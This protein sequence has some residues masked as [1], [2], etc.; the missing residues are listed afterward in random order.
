MTRLTR[1]LLPLVLGLLVASMAT[2]A[3]AQDRRTGQTMSKPVAKKLIAAQEMLQSGKVA[4]A[5]KEL[6]EVIKRRGLKPLELANVYNLFGYVANEENK[7]KQAITYFSKAIAQDALPLAQ[8]YTLEYNVAQL[9]MMQGNFEQALKILRAWFKKTRKKDSPVTPNGGNYYM[10]ALCYMNLDPPDVR[11][12]RKPA[13][14]AIETSENPAENWLRML[15]QIYYSQKEFVLLADVLETLI[16]RY[17]KPEYYTQLSGAYAE[18][19]EELKSLAVLQL[20][21]MQDLLERE[22]QINQLAQL[23][24]YHQIPYRAALVMEKGLTDGLVEP[25]LN[26]LRLLADAWIAAREADKAFE[27]LS[28]AAALAE[29]G[30]LYMRLGQAYVQKQKWEEADAA[31]GN[32]LEHSELKDRGN[33]HLLRGVARMNREHWDGARASFAA[34]QKYDDTKKAAAQYKKYLEARKD[35][36]ERLRS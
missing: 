8:Q 9:Y 4:S 33:V 12:A 31:L 25:D 29:D 18:S 6:Q 3:L 13:E 26:N 24:L 5:K 10:L 2:S 1:I 27:P 35:Q 32:A 15:G 17:N 30:D 34:A 16:E 22:S 14:L 11:H 23:Y 28:K 20:A 36:L 19:G 7:P 21:Y